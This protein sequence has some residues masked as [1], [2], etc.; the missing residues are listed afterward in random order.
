VKTH[1]TELRKN[2][3]RIAFIASEM[4][5]RGKASRQGLKEIGEL[6]DKAKAAWEKA[7]AL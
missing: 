4:L 5:F 6:L 3:A 7:C 1:L 2:C